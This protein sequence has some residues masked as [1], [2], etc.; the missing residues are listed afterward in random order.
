MQCV[1]LICDIILYSSY[2]RVFLCSNMRWYDVPVPFSPHHCKSF[3]H[4]RR[5]DL[6]HSNDSH[7]VPFHI[8]RFSSYFLYYFGMACPLKYPRERVTAHWNSNTFCTWILKS[9][10][11]SMITNEPPSTLIERDQKNYKKLEILTSICRT[12]PA[13]Q[14]IVSSG[15]HSN[16]SVDC[17][18]IN[19]CHH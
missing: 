17:K 2:S 7:N 15:G 16:A 14:N 5:L 6:C 19:P 11:S 10:Y 1:L 12:K 3:T 9:S 18:S 4:A 13:S 8:S